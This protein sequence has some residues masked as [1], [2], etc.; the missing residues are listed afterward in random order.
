VLLHERDDEDDE[1]EEQDD[2]ARGDGC[3]DGER[4]AVTER[5]EL[6]GER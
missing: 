1:P 5:D 4:F 3:G 6:V 2:H